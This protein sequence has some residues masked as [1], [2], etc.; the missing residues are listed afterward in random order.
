M[1]KTFQVRAETEIASESY[2][3]K[4]KCVFPGLNG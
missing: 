1:Y 4:K 3:K 2:Q